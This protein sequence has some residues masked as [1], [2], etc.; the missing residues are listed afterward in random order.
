MCS[1]PSHCV[2]G[3][4]SWP[5]QNPD[6]LFV[7]S[8]PSGASVYVNTV[9]GGTTPVTIPL[10]KDGPHTVLLTLTGYTDYDQTINVNAGQTYVINHPFTQSQPSSTTGSLAVMS[11]P[12][13]ATI[14]LDGK[15]Q[16]LTPATLSDLSTGD[17]TAKLTRSGYWDFSQT[18]HID[19][20]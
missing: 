13:G 9:Y 8:N 3:V 20:G 4:C 1:G 19:A 7:S 11:T 12:S 6:T 14:I 15:N 18:V 5:S 2:N 10:L 17:H 16:G